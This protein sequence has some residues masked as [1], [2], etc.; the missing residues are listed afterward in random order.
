ME[1]DTPE[2]IRESLLKIVGSN[3]SD[4]ILINENQDFELKE[5]AL[6]KVMQYA[7]LRTITGFLNSSF[8]GVLFIGVNDDKKILG[9]KKT[10]QKFEDVDTYE[11]ALLERIRTKLDNALTHI[12]ENIKFHFF[13]DEERI[14]S[15]I[16]VKPFFPTTN[17]TL[18]FC[19]YKD[20]GESQEKKTFFKRSG[21]TTVIMT[22]HEVAMDMLIFRRKGE[23][24]NPAAP[25]ADAER[26][27]RGYS[28]TDEYYLLKRV[29]PHAEF[30]TKDG[31]K[32][33]RTILIL[34]KENGD[35]IKKYRNEDWRFT[36]EFI[37]KAQSLVGR[38]VKLT[39][40]QDSGKEKNFWW[41]R[42]FVA[43]IYAV[44]LN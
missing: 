8:G 22:A 3:P 31:K 24:S 11:Q 30:T 34:G 9:L 10:E 20:K 41:D 12:N 18:A 43:N 39:S 44:N 2:Q 17:Q 13:N 4:P 21:T 6:N 33:A 19:D 38:K 27:G 40:W 25:K 42:G 37:K 7:L 35:E 29:E 16:Q 32:V 15:A 1:F 26:E 36:E 14:V 5:S 28:I 23:L